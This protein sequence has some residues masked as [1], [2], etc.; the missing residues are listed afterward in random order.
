M[1]FF[2]HFFHLK[3]HTKIQV[4]KLF[5][6]DNFFNFNFLTNSQSSA[7]QS[8]DSDPHSSHPPN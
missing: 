5:V 3:K 8:Y 2:L 4:S 6:K 1:G 7:P